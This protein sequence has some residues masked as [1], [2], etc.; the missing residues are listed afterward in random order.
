M[1][2]FIVVWTIGDIIGAIFWGTVIL[3]FAVS[4]AMIG[5]D[6]M[7]RRLRAWWRK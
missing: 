4:V 2:H 1:P 5:T 3:I 7:M 6:A